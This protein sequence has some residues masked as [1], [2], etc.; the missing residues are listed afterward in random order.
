MAISKR[1]RFEVFKRDRFTCQYCGKTPPDVTL[2]IDHVQ[3][4]SH[5]GTDE[6]VNLVTACF[7]CN[8]GKGPVILSALSPSVTEAQQREVERYEQTKALN[9]WLTKL[10]KEQDAAIERISR[11]WCEAVHPG[12]GIEYTLSQD[13]RR[14]VRTFLKRLPEAEVLDAVDVAF[15][16]KP[17]GGEAA[18][19]YFCGVCWKKIK[20][21]GHDG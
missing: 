1:T 5:G 14:S 15:R 4:V 9:R 21:G 17:H 19:R 12:C 18:F 8:R 13:S 7:D 3:P 16:R 20:D 11:Y 6:K 2:E 10:R